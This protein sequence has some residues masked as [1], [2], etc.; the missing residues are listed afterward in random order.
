MSLSERDL[1]VGARR[2]DLD[3]LAQIYDRYQP[4]LYS[5]AMRLLGDPILAEDC[6]A[7]TFLRFLKALQGGNGPQDYLQAYL[8]RI[9]HNWITDFYRRQPPPVLELAEHLQSG[10]GSHPDVQAERQLVR[11]QMLAALHRL[12]PEQRQVVVLRFFEGC[13]IECVATALQKPTGAV[14]ALQHRALAALGRLL[15]PEG[16]REVE[17][18][19]GTRDRSTPVEVV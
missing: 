15:I 4:R 12:T 8:Y 19:P 17:N 1:L 6:V 18:V 11:E 9:A 14:K 2:F 7:E 3:V 5:Y 16:M 13:S 10:E